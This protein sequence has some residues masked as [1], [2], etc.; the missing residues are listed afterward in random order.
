MLGGLYTL[1]AI[2]LSLSAGVMRFVNIAHGDFIVLACYAAASAHDGAR[3]RPGGRDIDRAAVRL[4]VGLWPCSGFCCN[5]SS[6]RTCSWSFSLPLP[7]RSSSRM[8]CW[9]AFGADPQKISGGWME[10]AT[11]ALGSG[12]NVGLFQIV[13]FFAAVVLV[14]VLDSCCTAP[15][16]GPRS[17]RSPMT[18]PPPISSV[19]RR[20]AFTP[21]PWASP[22]SPSASPRASCRSGPIS[23]PPPARRD[24]WSRSR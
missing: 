3:P 17:A 10:T 15:A 22:S 14:A 6:A 11:V 5:A 24:C 19:C 7:C 9:K 21:W 23:I 2:G 1:F 18:S 12:I 4:P 8:G 13:T 20:C 16:S